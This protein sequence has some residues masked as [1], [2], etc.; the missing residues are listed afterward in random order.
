MGSIK[1]APKV[2]G[3]SQSSKFRLLWKGLSGAWAREGGGNILLLTKF[4]V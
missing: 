3:G 4:F 1:W 2:F